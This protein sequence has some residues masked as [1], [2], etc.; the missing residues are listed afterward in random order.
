MLIPDKKIHPCFHTGV[1][2]ICDQILLKGTLLV[3]GGEIF[4]TD[5]KIIELY[6]N[7]DEQAI[8]E[9]QIKYGNLCFKVAMNILNVS[10]D[11]EE[12]V[13]DTYLGAWN[14]IPPQ[15]PNVF[16]AFLI[17]ITRN[18]SL[19][20]L[21]FKTAQ[22]RGNGEA[23]LSFDELSECI[24]DSC[25]IVDA[26]EENELAK[27]ISEFLRALPGA[28]RRIFIRRYFFCD[29]IEEISKQFGY[30]ES[31]VKMKLMR[32]RNKLRTHLTERGLVK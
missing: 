14:S 23:T 19:K 11:A 25:N 10:E 22:K 31:K 9:T 32:T 3:K 24:P 21:R 13:N 4:M 30:G 7:R 16:S 5:E 12:A 28:E 18:L 1:L 8:R 6:F 17:K 20:K 26:V 27:V 15:R 2:N 29:S